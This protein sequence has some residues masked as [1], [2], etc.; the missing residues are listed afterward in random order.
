VKSTDLVPIETGGDTVMDV[1]ATGVISRPPELR[2]FAIDERLFEL[3]QCPTPLPIG[4]RSRVSRT[5]RLKRQ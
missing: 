2:Q 3:R 5:S 4:M 1:V